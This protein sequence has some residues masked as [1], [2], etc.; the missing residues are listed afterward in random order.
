MVSKYEENN[1]PLDIVWLDYTLLNN[2][3]NFEVNKTAFPDL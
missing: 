3:T 2:Y 1:L